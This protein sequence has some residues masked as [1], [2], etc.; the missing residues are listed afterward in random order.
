MISATEINIEALF[1]LCNFL[2]LQAISGL[3]PIAFYLVL[4]SQESDI[5]IVGHI[6]GDRKILKSVKKYCALT[7][8]I[9]SLFLIYKIIQWG[10]G[11]LG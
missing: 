6:F 1:T 3:L 9:I 5:L 4:L 7:G 8:S 2:L 11:V 10:F